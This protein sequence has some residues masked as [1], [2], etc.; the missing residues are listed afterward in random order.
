MNNQE[1]FTTLSH[2]LKVHLEQ[3]CKQYHPSYPIRFSSFLRF[4]AFWLFCV[5]VCLFKQIYILIYTWLWISN[6]KNHPADF[7]KHT[8]LFFL[9]GFSFM[10]IHDSCLGGGGGN[11][12]GG[13][14]NV[15]IKIAWYQSKEYFWNN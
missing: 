3:I 13:S 5:R 7:G 9:S 4:L 6:K 12:V 2:K 8:T 15:N 1:K 14:C 11:F 10:N